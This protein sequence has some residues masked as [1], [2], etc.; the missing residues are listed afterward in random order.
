MTTNGMNDCDGFNHGRHLRN[1]ER[2][3]QLVRDRVVGVARRQCGQYGLI[4]LGPGGIG[5]NH[6]VQ[7][8]L[9]RLRV[10][11]RLLNTHWTPLSLFSTLAQHPD[12]I[13]VLDDVEEV[14]CERTA[15]GVLRSATWPCRKDRGGNE[16]RVVT[17]SARGKTQEVV[18]RGG[19]IVI[20]NRPLASMPE[21][22]ALAT[23]LTPVH[24]EVTD[25][26]IAALMRH[27]AASG[28]PAVWSGLKSVGG[29]N[30]G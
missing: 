24:L 11:Y 28:Y 5:K 23:R 7:A 17:W 27:V 16:E 3:F 30:F 12:C 13:H 1:L 2:K 26:E 20:S 6:T 19:I 4:L 14:L 21:L 25:E 29:C 8:E 15:L 10:P 22:K 9:G 18:F